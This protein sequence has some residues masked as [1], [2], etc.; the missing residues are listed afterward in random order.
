MKLLVTKRGFVSALGISQLV[1]WG[2]L[3]YS[4]PLIAE[5]ITY[6]MKWSRA[7]LYG[8]ASLGLLAAT[9]LAYPVGVIIDRGQGRKL[10][11]S[12][13]VFASIALIIWSQI[14]T[15]RAFY[16]VAISIGALQA[17]LLYES[18]FAVTVHQLGKPDSRS[19]I[20]AITLWAGFSSTLFIPLIQFILDHLGWRDTLV[21][22]GGINMAITAPLYFWAIRPAQ[23]DKKNRPIS[24]DAPR[25][26][27]RSILLSQRFF[28]LTASFSLYMALFSAFTYHIYP[29]LISLSFDTYSVVFAIGLI[30]PAQIA[31]RVV[32]LLFNR[33]TIIHL[34]LL[35]SMSFPIALLMLKLSPTHITLGALCILYGAAN[36]IFTI[37]RGM[38][39]PELLSHRNYGKING[40]MLV[41][42]SLFRA[43]APWIIAF[44][45]TDSQSA[46]N[47]IN[48]MLAFA[49][50][51]PVLF[52]LAIKS[53]R[54]AR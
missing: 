31:G 53:R 38:A 29:L 12:A 6:E 26:Q 13:T 35:A 11:V 36:G 1:S 19:A 48:L 43:C 44:Y 17:A 18:A 14:E 25:S 33:L 2:T 23:P 39:V 10:M 22:L 5:A 8:A 34:G 4:F 50:L 7:D 42:M 37:V 24:L 15:L 3:F 47:A 28:F 52:V 45:W 27:I 51:V 21:C 9:V 41:P 40:V 46:D 20:T 32:I 30:G 49:I 16:I 54:S